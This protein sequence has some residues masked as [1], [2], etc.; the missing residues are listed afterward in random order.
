MLWGGPSWSGLIGC[1][2]LEGSYRERVGV[3]LVA[4]WRVEG[5]VVE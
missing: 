2:G 5:W 1:L 3:L 4:W